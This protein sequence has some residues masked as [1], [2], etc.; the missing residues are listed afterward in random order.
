MN[1]KKPWN[2]TA[3]YT[4]I[5]R[6]GDARLKQIGFGVA[7]LTAG[8]TYEADAA[9]KETAVIVLGGTISVRCGG[10]TFEKIGLRA[11][12]FDGKPATVYCP[13]GG[14]IAI[15]AQTD[16]EVALCQAP[17]DRHGAPCLIA[18]DRVKEV[19]IGRDNFTRTAYMIVDDSVPAHYLFIGEAL[20]P[21]GNWASYPPHRHDKDD[22][23]REVDME[24]VYFFRFQPKHGFGIQRIYTDDRSIDETLPLAENDTV[25]IPEG[26][27]P[28]V[29]APGY[30]MWYLWIM[31]GR[32]RKFLSRPDP[33]HAWVTAR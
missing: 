6:P 14:A 13:A 21:P 23:P 3:G 20:V 9:Q 16:A 7:C 10:Q 18:P 30:R 15:S 5:V 24:E 11:T 25:L 28:V 4:Q 19:T 26:Y 12:V 32:N 31:A 27:H 8:Q 33:D 2:L 17:S 1:Y 29:A 22:L